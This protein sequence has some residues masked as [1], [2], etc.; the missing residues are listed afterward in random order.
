MAVL[1]NPST[2][3]AAAPVIVTSPTARCGTTLVQRL[4]SSSDNAFVYGEDVGNQMRILTSLFSAQI[5]A[6]ERTA[7]DVDATFWR[8]IDGTLDEWRPGLAPPVNVTLSAWTDIYYQLPLGLAKFG[9]SIGRPIW[10]FKWPAYPSE[11]LKTFL[12]LMPKAKIV[13][14]VRNLEDTLKSAKA[15]RFVTTEEQVLAFCQAWTSNLQGVAD[16]KQRDQVMILHYEALLEQRRKQ[17][18]A[19]QAF[20]GASN[21][22]MTEFDLKVNTFTG[23]PEKGYAPDGYIP[24]EPL[25]AVESE[26]VQSYSVALGD[27]LMIG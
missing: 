22:R 13:Y 23:A 25:D 12:A 2:Y 21:I 17:I 3:L 26:I 5:V 27:D 10:G 11:V 1:D 18:D 20:T 19:L 15:R 16:L 8:A 6:A 9:R 7:A 24:P 4:I 14:V